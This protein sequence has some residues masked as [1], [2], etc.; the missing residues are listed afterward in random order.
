[1]DQGLMS[2]QWAAMP[3]WD[4]CASD[5]RSRTDPA[6]GQRVVVEARQTDPSSTAIP[7]RPPQAEDGVA[8]EG[9]GGLAAGC[10]KRRNGRARGVVPRCT[11]RIE[12][13]NRFG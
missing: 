11:A 6:L 4:R 7:A 12:C 9:L 1:M 10:D 13:A 8:E 3:V 5:R 2:M